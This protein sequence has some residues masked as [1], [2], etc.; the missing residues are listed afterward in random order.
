MRSTEPSW[1]FSYEPSPFVL[2]FGV[3][4]PV[5]EIAGGGPAQALTLTF[6]PIT[7]NLRH[8]EGKDLHLQGE[9]PVE[10]L[11]LGEQDELV[12]ANEPLQYDLEVE[13]TGPNLF[14]HGNLH[15][16][17]DCECARC[18]TPF[19]FPIDLEPYNALVPLE[20]EDKAAVSNDVVDLTPYVREDILLAFPQHPLCEAECDRLPPSALSDGSKLSGTSA[21][22]R[23]SAWD[24]LNKLKFK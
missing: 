3:G 24:E 9:L 7:V 8:L 15:L 10:E 23:E 12:H 21:P 18:L 4:T 6:M 11:D 22:V 14:V 1:N 13:K 19:K 16:E 2:H 17:L 20:G 5:P